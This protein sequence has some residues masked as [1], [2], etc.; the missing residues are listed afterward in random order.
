MT[1]AACAQ[2]LE[3]VLNRLENVSASVNFATE[4][5]QITAGAEQFTLI[6]QAIH[7]AGFQIPE[8][9]Y[10]FNIAGMTCAACA[11]RLEKTLNRQAGIRATVNFAN[12]HAQI[13]TI[14]GQWQTAQLISLIEKT[15][16]QASELA[17]TSSQAKQHTP[18]TLWLAIACTLPFLYEMAGMLAGQHGVLAPL[19]QLALATIVQFIPGWRFYRGAFLSLRGGAANMDVLVALG[20]SA[21]WAYS[22]WALLSQH[23]A[24][25]FEASSSVITLV[26]L[27]KWLELRAKQQTGDALKALLQLQPQTAKVLRNGQWQ[28]LSIAAIALGDQVQ[29]RDGETVP[30]DGEIIQGQ[31]EID[32]AMLTGE[33]A[34]ISKAVGSPVF[35]GTRN[36]AGSAQIK[37]S[38]IGSQTQLAAI[39]KLVSQA[40]GS[41]APIQKLADRISAIFV[42]VILLVALITLLATYWLQG[43]LSLALIHAVAVLVI[44]C[45]CALGLATP[46]AVMVGVGLGARHGILFRNATALELASQID[47]LIVDK[48]G[49]L[50]VGKPQI[51]HIQRFDSSPYTEQQLLH[52]AAGIEA[53]SQHPLAEAFLKAHQLSSGDL[54]L[55]NGAAIS[56]EIG[57]GI[58][59]Q[60]E[61]HLIRIGRPDWAFLS[62]TS[63]FDTALQYQEQGY[64][65]IGISIDTLPC[66]VFMLQDEIRRSSYEAIRHLQKIG[67]NVIMLTGDNEHSAIQ[68]ASRLGITQ[69]QAQCSPQDK[70]QQLLQLQQAGKKVAMVGD[71]I[72]DAPA[73]AAADV[74]FA[75]KT[76]ASVALETADITL[77]HNDINHISAAIALSKATLRK[78]RQN[79]FFAFIYNILG[80]PL[81]AVGLLNP[82]VA[83]A[84]MALSSVSVISN[85][86]LLKRFKW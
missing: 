45:P 54:P 55:L 61:S 43:D 71:G 28:E 11:N 62:D 57:M 15:G 44:A 68:V 40:Q 77:M 72:N 49:T 36:L 20:T 52:W 3:K 38:A 17:Q 13:Y 8:Q 73:L 63:K 14:A 60:I 41:K 64:T 50:T 27:G 29:L 80:I 82:I 18:W 51:A 32:E 37:T 67:V 9:Y 59:G 79:L 85:A 26:L 19:L 76:G 4:Q 7:K 48:T 42:P 56:T 22:V 30:V 75:M 23:H 66:A 53:S 25:Y 47:T 35:A 78:I 24:L 86:L 10:E 33:S 39:V 34:S 81:A 58:S 70:F 46:A 16:F 12:E 21:A 2:R 6:E 84:A 5:A 65:V 74:S 31:I 83:G 69:Y 1:C